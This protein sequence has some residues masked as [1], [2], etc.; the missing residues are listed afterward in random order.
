MRIG[1][2]CFCALEK[3]VK[4]CS[5]VTRRRGVC[6]NEYEDVLTPIKFCRLLGVGTGRNKCNS[7]LSKSDFIQPLSQ[8]HPHVTDLMKIHAWEPRKRKGETVGVQNRQRTTVSHYRCTTIRKTTS[9][10]QYRIRIVSA[11]RTNSILFLGQAG[12]DIVPEH[13]SHRGSTGAPLALPNSSADRSE[14]S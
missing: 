11:K 10:T 7:K 2:R 5:M 4:I 13:S 8:W 1:S 3:V 12:H 9:P 14:P 6:H